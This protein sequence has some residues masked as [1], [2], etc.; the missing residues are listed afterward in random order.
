MHRILCEKCVRNNQRVVILQS[1]EEAISYETLQPFSCR[2]EESV[3]L[4]QRVI[5][6]IWGKLQVKRRRYLAIR[7]CSIYQQWNTEKFE[8]V[9]R[10]RLHHLYRNA[11]RRIKKFIEVEKHVKQ[12]E[13]TRKNI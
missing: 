12:F 6:V 1:L 2:K 7:F 11:A 3:F 9:C 13:D 10:L 4:L 8:V 5:R